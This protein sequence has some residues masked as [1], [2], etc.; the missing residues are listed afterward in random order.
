MKK[1]LL[2]ALAALMVP[3]VALA[4]GKPP[5][6]GAHTNKGNAKVMYV[7]KGDIY[8]YVAYDPATGTG[9]IMIDVKH[10][11]RHGKLLVGQSIP[12]TLGPN[13]KVL[14]ENGV[15]SIAATQPGDQGMIKIR[16][17]RM[18]FKGATTALMTNALA[19]LPA[20]T[21]VDWGTAPT[22]S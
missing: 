22:S 5:T 14:M 8:N 19:N 17:P 2:F 21:V 6:A 18:A 11:N 4:K 13:S 20:K 9:S 12:I 3:G 1:A 10:S 7:L 15:T 16:A